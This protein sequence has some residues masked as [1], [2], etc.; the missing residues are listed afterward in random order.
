MEALFFRYEGEGLMLPTKYLTQERVFLKLLP[1]LSFGFNH[2]IGFNH[3]IRF[4]HSILDTSRE[5]LFHDPVFRFKIQKVSLWP[6]PWV[7]KYLL[8][9]CQSL[10]TE[11]KSRS[12]VFYMRLRQMISSFSFPFPCHGHNMSSWPSGMSKLFFRCKIK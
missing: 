3:I 6:C 11:Y 1:R 7:T 12:D 10:N 4:Y 2:R 5:P 9:Q 8:N